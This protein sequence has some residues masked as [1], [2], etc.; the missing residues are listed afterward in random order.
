MI[1]LRF[2]GKHEKGNDGMEELNGMTK[3][4]MED[5]LRFMRR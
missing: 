4:Q 3:E 2:R 1:L 5:E